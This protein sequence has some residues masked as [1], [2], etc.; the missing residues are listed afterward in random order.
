MCLTLCTFCH[1]VWLVMARSPDWYMTTWVHRYI[2]LRMHNYAYPNGLCDTEQFQYMSAIQYIIPWVCRWHASWVCKLHPLQWCCQE[3]EVGAKLQGSGAEFPS[4]VQ[5]QSPGGDLGAKKHDI[6]FAIRISLVSSHKSDST[7]LLP[8]RAPTTMCWHSRWICAN[9]R[10]ES[11]ASLG[12]L[13]PTS[14][15]C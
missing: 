2:S 6:N 8:H 11:R 7:K 15:W 10:I 4:R 14:W 13:P 9:L 12:A 5:R 3:A 1:P